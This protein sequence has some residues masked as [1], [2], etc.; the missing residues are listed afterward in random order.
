MKTETWFFLILLIIFILLFW[1]FYW[2]IQLM[3]NSGGVSLYTPPSFTINPGKENQ[4]NTTTKEGKEYMKTKRVVISGLLRNT[5]SRIP[6]I[7]RR[8]EALGN[9][10]YDYRV[11]VVENDSTDNSRELLLEWS[12]RNPKVTILGCGYNAN[13]CSLGFKPTEG[14]SVYR[15]RIEK[16]VYL[17]NIYL[18]EIKNNYSDYDYAIVWDFDIVGSVYLDGI[19]NSFGYL[20]KDPNLD[21][22]CSYGIYS[23]GPMKLFYDTYATL[24]KG[25]NFHIDN[26]KSHDLRKG[27]GMG[28]RYNR[29]DP[30]V[31]VISCF[32]GFAIYRIQS[33]LHPSVYYDM[34]SKEDNN[35]ECE[36]V[37]LH[38]R[39]KNSVIKMNPNMIHLVVYNP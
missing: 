12:K 35:L 11:L 14:H 38:K 10:F 16:M 24:E 18:E 22:M 36:H 23:W 7:E 15:S 9:L 19:Q 33:I 39:M 3:Y 8:V 5:A 32:S 13:N 1:K 30:P 4:V 21:V 6:E 27:I 20:K 34:T 28:L 26:K 25:D 29:G 2:R 37:V 17:R 31:R